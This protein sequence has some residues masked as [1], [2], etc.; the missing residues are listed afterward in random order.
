[1]DGDTPLIIASQKGKINVVKLLLAA[2]AGVN[3]TKTNGMTPLWA[4]SGN[5]CTEIVR[6]LLEQPI[7]LNKSKEYCDNISTPSPSRSPLFHGFRCR[8]KI[9]LLVLHI[10]CFLSHIYYNSIG[11]VVLK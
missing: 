4:A 8:S 9:T 5:G 11:I 3:Q 1:M 2:G 10:G 6:L 7:T